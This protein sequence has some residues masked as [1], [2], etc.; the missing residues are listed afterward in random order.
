MH[1]F[2][3]VIICAAARSMALRNVTPEASETNRFRRFKESLNQKFLL[4]A[5]IFGNIFYHFSRFQA[6]ALFHS[7]ET[8]HFKGLKFVN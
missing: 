7:I 8:T 2:D 1:E 4:F 6:W 5:V 3:E